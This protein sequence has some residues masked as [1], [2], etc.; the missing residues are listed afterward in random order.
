MTDRVPNLNDVNSIL[1]YGAEAQS[2]VAEFSE[3]ALKN[4][5]SKDLGEVGG[6]IAE[7]ITHL[8]EPT[9]D[10]IPLRP[11]RKTVRGL[12]ARCRRAC[13]AVDRISL[14]LQGQR[15][16]LMK[17][18]EM[19]DLLYAMN[20]EQYDNLTDHLSRGREALL[21]F[22][23]ETL[24]PR[25]AQAEEGGSPAEIQAARDAQDQYDRF[26]KKLHDL[27]LTRAVSL[28][29]APQIRL[30]QNNNSVLAEKIQSSVVN[31]IPL[32][33]SQMVLT[34]GMEN[35]RTAIE[36]QE[37]VA[38]ITNTLLLRNAQKL[39]DTSLA[40]TREGE[41]ACINTETLKQTNAILIE[42]LDEML[43]LR[44]EGRK[45]RLEAEAE[46][47]RLDGEIR[48]R[49]LGRYET[50]AIEKSPRVGNSSPILGPT[51]DKN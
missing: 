9:E 8:K 41:R 15:D 45:A 23:E 51:G 21:R 11:F 5:K 35:A 40:V 20:R 48:L 12:K 42:T 22:R 7:L 4:L 18:I 36:M 27:E 3:I 33:K 1:N 49:L 19:L 30:L 13:E 31:T 50:K 2:R 32:W 38:D 26:E 28:Q 17:D 24:L 37:K 25:R 39:K 6:K 47:R 46:L 29:M 16:L 34:L 43:R 14:S 10:K 44:E